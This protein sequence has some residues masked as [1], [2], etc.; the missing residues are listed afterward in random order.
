MGLVA[1]QEPSR[2]GRQDPKHEMHGSVGSLL[3]GEDGSKAAGCV[4]V[5]EPSRLGWYGPIPLDMW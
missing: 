4:V 3:S 2:A 5:P 1:A